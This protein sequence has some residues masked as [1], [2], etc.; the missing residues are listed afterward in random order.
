MAELD[1]LPFEVKSWQ[2]MWR[3]DPKPPS[4][5]R[6]QCFERAFDTRQQFLLNK[7]G[8]RFFVF[9][10][11]RRQKGLNSWRVSP[12]FSEEDQREG[13][14]G[15]GGAFAMAARACQAPGP[16]PLTPW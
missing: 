2:A 6:P 9:G 11:Q 8:A 1:W 5:M 3:H 14:R 10:Y 12:C 16:R 4:N 13:G 7:Y 15:G